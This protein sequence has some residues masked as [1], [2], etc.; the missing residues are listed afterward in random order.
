MVSEVGVVVSEAGVGARNGKS[1]AHP[2]P[3]CFSLWKLHRLLASVLAHSALLMHLC[4]VLFITVGVP[5]VVP[6]RRAMLDLLWASSSCLLT[7]L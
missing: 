6:V 2:P 3:T 5:D 1:E 7:L 4:T